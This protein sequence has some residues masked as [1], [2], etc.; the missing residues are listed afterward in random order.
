MMAAAGGAGATHRIVMAPPGTLG[1][2]FGPAPYKTEFGPF[3]DWIDPLVRRV[4][5]RRMRR[6]TRS[7]ESPCHTMGAPVVRLTFVAPCRGW[8]GWVAG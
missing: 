2:A 3:I 6:R 7:A 1:L 4:S 5:R 8:G